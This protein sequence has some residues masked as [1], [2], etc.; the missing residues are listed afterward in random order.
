[1]VVYGIILENVANFEFDQLWGWDACFVL[2][3]KFSQ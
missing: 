3:V 2:V 1:M